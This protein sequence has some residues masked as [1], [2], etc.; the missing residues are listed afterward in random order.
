M[1][2]WQ[3][4]MIQNV[5]IESTNLCNMQCSF[6][7]FHGEKSLRMGDSGKTGYMPIEKFEDILR[8]LSESKLC[9]TDAYVSPQWRGEPFLVKDIEERVIQILKRG[10]RTGLITNGILADNQCLKRLAECGVDSVSFSIDASSQ[11]VYEKLR[12][13]KNSHSAPVLEQIEKKIRY[14]I[15]LKEQ[16]N[17]ATTIQVSFVV[18]KI[19]AGEAH[20]FAEKWLSL[21]CNVVFQSQGRLVEAGNWRT[22][23]NK[24]IKSPKSRKQCNLLTN[25]I[26]FDFKGDSY[27]CCHDY[28][29]EIKCGNI[30]K[31]GFDSIAN[32]CGRLQILSSQLDCQWNELPSFCKN[33]EVWLEGEPSTRIFSGEYINVDAGYLALTLSPSQ[34]TRK[35]GGMGLH[36]EIMK[37]LKLLQSAS[38]GRHFFY[39]IF[40]MLR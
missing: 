17:L 11:A 28:L 21:G 10:F 5:V 7:T 19:N 16:K 13:K 32:S 24:F 31:D 12:M 3:E 40:K 1:G 37:N 38:S 2:F 27:I 9:A 14:L 29:R 22:Y 23:G 6:C 36:R 4:T 33:C 26:L 25:G 30:F 20:D 39:N 35:N 34:K 8:I 18:N 15:E